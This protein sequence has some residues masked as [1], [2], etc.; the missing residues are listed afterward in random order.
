VSEFSEMNLVMRNVFLWLLTVVLLATDCRTKG[1]ES[2][3]FSMIRFL[4][5]LNFHE[6]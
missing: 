2:G 4:R 1:Q 5:S 3:N 6:L